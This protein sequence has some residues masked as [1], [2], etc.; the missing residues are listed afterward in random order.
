M[1]ANPSHCPT[2]SVGGSGPSDI[3]LAESEVRGRGEED[4]KRRAQGTVAD[5][6]CGCLE[7]RVEPPPA[8][9][10]KEHSQKEAL[11]EGGGAGDEGT[12]GNKD[13]PA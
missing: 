8:R 5:E 10:V 13:N 7:D 12:A 4:G 6:G 3:R 9:A 1:R 11:E 2:R